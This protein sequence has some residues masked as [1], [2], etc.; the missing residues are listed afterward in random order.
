MNTLWGNIFK[1]RQKEEDEISGI[2]KKIP[3]FTGLSAREI[4]AI[5][6]I[7]HRR[8]YLQNEVI[9]HEGDPGLGMYII[10]KGCVD[11]VHGPDRHM[12]A[13]L[14]EGEFFGEL[15]LL[16]ESP[17]TATAVAKMPCKLLC[18]F[19]PDLFSLIDRK[20]GLGVKVLFRLAKTIGDR[21]KKTNDNL[22]ELKKGIA[23][24]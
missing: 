24:I 12:L 22:L 14:C 6:R 9:F 15:A 4:A 21:L 18:F 20:P 1:D 7:L 19:H 11:I 23:E 10:E 2:L 17:R 13:S 8:E 16:D 5:E 3:I